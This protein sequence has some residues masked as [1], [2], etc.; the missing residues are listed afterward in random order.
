MTRHC[1]GPDCMVRIGG[2]PGGDF[3]DT[4]QPTVTVE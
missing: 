2:G 3:E 1:R 4:V